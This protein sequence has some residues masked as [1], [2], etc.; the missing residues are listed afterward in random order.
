MP[1]GIFFRLQESSMS[2]RRLSRM[3]LTAS[4]AFGGI[5]SAHAESF[6]CSA[7]LGRNPPSPTATNIFA[8]MDADNR[9]QAEAR[10]LAE[11][12]KLPISARGI[13]NL[14]CKPN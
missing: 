4:L 6:L 12:R 11:L 2:P 3:L 5:A 9:Q 8:F 1:S 14:S 10:Y 7:Y 13:H